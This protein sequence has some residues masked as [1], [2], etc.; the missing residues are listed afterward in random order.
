[1]TCKLADGVR[2]NEY[3]LHLDDIDATE[4][5]SAPVITKDNLPPV[6]RSEVHEFIGET[7]THL[8]WTLFLFGVRIPFTA[9]FN[10]RMQTGTYAVGGNIVFQWN[11]ED[12]S[13]S[14]DLPYVM[15]KQG[16]KFVLSW[17]VTD[18]KETFDLQ[19]N[20]DSLNVLK[21]LDSGFQLSDQKVNLF[22]ATTIINEKQV[23]D[24]DIQ[25]AFEHLP[26]VLT[27]KILEK[28]GEVPVT[29]IAFHYASV[30]T[31]VL[32]ETIASFSELN[33]PETGLHS[34]NLYEWFSPPL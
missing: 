4:L 30:D 6:C 10:K 27:H 19:V 28:V 7:V 3:I 23:T 11:C 21:Y 8:T 33:F 12:P 32:N 1:M 16:Q 31:G 18:I 34:L 26:G 17:I 25:N 24:S 22:Q 14:S 2:G 15:A 29:E 5:P 9:E 20:N 13:E